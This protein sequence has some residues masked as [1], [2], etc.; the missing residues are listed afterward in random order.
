MNP[1]DS[2]RVERARDFRQ[3]FH[4]GHPAKRAVRRSKVGKAPRV[5]VKLGSL[6]AVT[7]ATRKGSD[8]YSHYEHDFGEE[9]GRKPDL[10]MDVD[11]GRL[12]IV[13]GDYTVEERGIVN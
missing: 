12:H 13:G 5:L 4:W 11:T 10:C 2:E 1:G 3:A 9:G 7:Y 6:Q 8:G